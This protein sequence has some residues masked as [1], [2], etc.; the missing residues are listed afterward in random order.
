M[1]KAHKS[2]GKTLFVVWPSKNKLVRLRNKIQFLQLL[3][4]FYLI[5]L[6]SKQIICFDFRKQ[7]SVL[8][9][10]FYVPWVILSE[11]LSA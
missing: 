8:P 4:V 9:M 3:P 5:Q 7:N 11:R 2:K 10:V 1:A 6:S